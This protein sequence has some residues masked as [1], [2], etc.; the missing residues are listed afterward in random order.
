L[1]VGSNPAS[2]IAVPLWENFS[3]T[4]PTRLKSCARLGISFVLWTGLCFSHF[5]RYNLL[6]Q[7]GT[8]GSWGRRYKARV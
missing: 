5:R 8:H 3:K 4:L 6:Q 7:I 1:I 2:N